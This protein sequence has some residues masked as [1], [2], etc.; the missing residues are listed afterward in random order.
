[1]YKTLAL[2]LHCF[3]LPDFILKTDFLVLTIDLFRSVLQPIKFPID[4]IMCDNHIFLFILFIFIATCSFFKNTT[5]V[6]LWA[7]PGYRK[8]FG[9][10]SV[11]YSLSIRGKTLSVSFSFKVLGDICLLLAS[12]GSLIFTSEW[13]LVILDIGTNAP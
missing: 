7:L 10:S 3:F 8:D 4:V 5:H 2:P 12:Y 6:S 11:S 9:G 1:M 13:K